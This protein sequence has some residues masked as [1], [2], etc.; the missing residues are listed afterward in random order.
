MNEIDELLELLN[1][2]FDRVEQ[3]DSGEIRAFHFNAVPTPVLSDMPLQEMREAALGLGVPAPDSGLPGAWDDDRD[4]SRVIVVPFTDESLDTYGTAFDADGWDF[5]R[6]KKNPVVFF[7]HES[8]RLPIGLGLKLEQSP[9]V[10]KDG[11]TRN[12][13]K[14]HALLSGSDLNPDAEP[15]LKNWMAGRFRGSSVGFRPIKMEPASDEERTRMN[16][17]E[18]EEA[19]IIREAELLEISLVPVPSNASALARSIKNEERETEQE[20]TEET[21]DVVED[22]RAGA[23]WDITRTEESGDI[24]AIRIRRTA[25]D[26][27]LDG[28]GS[29][30]NPTHTSPSSKAV[31]NE[32]RA[33]HDMLAECR[34]L[35]DELKGKVAE[36]GQVQD[37]ESWTADS[38]AHEPTYF[39]EI[40]DLSEYFKSRKREEE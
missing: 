6:Y 26:A 36:V 23:N 31:D 25:E 29:S 13:W 20:T 35:L 30:G 17:G 14:L 40:F 18:K 15:I 4:P 33:L 10:G 34:E 12:G 24:L 9:I 5:R 27:P 16:I 8:D 3:N 38:S 28:S 21:A 2:R 32:A 19:Y 39:A 37:R 11:K 22:V 7:S 1:K